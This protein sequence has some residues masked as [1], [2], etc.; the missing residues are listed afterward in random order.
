MR[1]VLF[2]SS[3][4]LPL[5]L[6]SPALA[7]S[8]NTETIA[9]MQVR[10]YVPDTPPRL[11]GKRALM[12]SLHGCVQTAS[13]LQHGGNWEASAE[14]YGMV[15]AVPRV[16]DG[17]LLGC[18]DFSGSNHTRDSRDDGYVI[19]MVQ[20]LLART[21]LNLDPR[22]VYV[23]GLS[24]GGGETL[25]LGCLAPD[26]FAGVGAAAGPAV[27]SGACTTL[28][29]EYR[30]DLDTQVT[31]LIHGTMD[32]TVGIENSRA[33]ADANAA[34]YGATKEAS[35]TEVPGNG[36][37]QL[38]KDAEGPRVSLVIVSGMGHA[39]PAGKGPGGAFI[40][41]R[42]VDYPAYVTDFFFRNNRRVPRFPNRNDR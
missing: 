12:V 2:L 41:T 3:L 18:W 22:Q 35:T 23:T 32:G 17:G 15:V 25:V 13:A 19:Q 31:S 1:A 29:G 5:T 4:F 42:H 28:A 34:I 36:T 16:P 7:G 20:T 10:L 6:A 8:W 26:L 40:D 11:A 38:W 14:S 27:E 33:S 21:E 9:Q 39:W 37:E 24:S 30:R